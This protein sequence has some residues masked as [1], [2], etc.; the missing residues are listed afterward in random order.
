M[1]PT[2][3]TTA[4]SPGTGR[5]RPSAASRP[6]PRGSAGRCRPRSTTGPVPGRSEPGHRADAG[7]PPSSADTG[8]RGRR[9]RPDIAR[10]GRRRCWPP[11]GRPTPHRPRPRCSRPCRRTRARAPSVRRARSGGGSP[12]AEP[13]AAAPTPRGRC[14]TARRRPPR[15]A[16]PPAR[17]DRGGAL[18]RSAGLAGRAAPLPACRRP[19]PSRSPGGLGAGADR[20]RARPLRG[21]GRAGLRPVGEHLGV[22]VRH[23]LDGRP[24]RVAAVSQLER[25]SGHEADRW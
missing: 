16:T 10:T 7:P 20:I 19:V 21:S 9:R 15:R 3:T 18:V 14:H 11:P 22:A 6:L 25:S 5:R 17:A 24:P 2:P 12:S 8:W 1:P 4:G 13:G 23:Q